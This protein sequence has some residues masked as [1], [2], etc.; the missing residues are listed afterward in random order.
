MAGLPKNHPG[1]KVIGSSTCLA[2]HLPR[3]KSI[4]PSYAEV[5]Q[6]YAKDD[7]ATETLIKKI[8][9]GGVGVWGKQPMPAHSQHTHEEASQ[10]VDAIMKVK[11]P[12]RKKK[13]K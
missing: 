4:G 13:T 9:E 12:Q 1:S 2:C 8:L 10:M 6:K 11:I 5:A 7:N 3:K